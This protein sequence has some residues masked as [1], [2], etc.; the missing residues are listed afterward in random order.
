[1]L[2][3][4]LTACAAIRVKS[5]PGAVTAGAAARDGVAG[6]TV[7]STLVSARDSD[8]LRM[9]PVS[10][11]PATKPVTSRTAAGTNRFIGCES[12]DVHAS[13]AAVAGLR[14]RDREQAVLEIG[15]D[16]VDDHG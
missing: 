2:A 10:T 3:T 15:R 11:R 13:R 14:H 8:A 9:R 12:G 1:M 6:D 5:G 7:C 4:P 16:A